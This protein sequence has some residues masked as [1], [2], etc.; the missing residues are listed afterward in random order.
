M[1]RNKKSPSFLQ[2]ISGRVDFFRSIGKEERTKK[3]GQALDKLRSFTGGKDLT[4]DDITPDRMMQFSAW[5]EQ[6]GNCPNTISFYNRI[7]RALY[8]QAVEDGITEDRRP[9]RKS[10]CG[11]EKTVKRAIP[12]SRVRTLA[13]M[14]FITKGKER[15]S[16]EYA[17]DMFM[18]SFYFRGMSFIDMA[19]LKKTDI[20]QGTVIYRRHKT[21]Q[22]LSIKIEPPMR[23]I[24]KRIGGGEDSPYV[25]DVIRREGKERDDVRA[26]NYRINKSLHKIGRLIGVDKLTMYV[27]RHS[28]ASACKAS[29]IPISVI[30]EGMGH[31]SEETTRIYLA[32]LDTSVV[33]NANRKIINQVI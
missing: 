8:N 28:W 19:F 17:R 22:R 25:L 1:G 13:N 27:A 3:Y 20:Q 18:L 29:N 30:S 15:R 24:M 4:F 2:Y 9:F 21:G 12:I 5:C 6:Q 14:E 23:D 10:F 32:Q 7:L 31:D 16:M 33:D 26:A 11:N